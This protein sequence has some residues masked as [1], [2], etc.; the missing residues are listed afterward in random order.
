M[1][2]Q[3]PQAQQYMKQVKR[4][5]TCSRKQRHGLIS[6][7]EQMIGMFS[8]DCPDASYEQIRTA[9]GSPTE[10][11]AELLSDIPEQEMTRICRSKKWI[12]IAATAC[13]TAITIGAC[14]A[15]VYFIRHP[16][17]AEIVTV[18]YEENIPE[19]WEYIQKYGL[20]Y[21]LDEDGN[22]VLATDKDGNEIEVDEK[23]IPI[24]ELKYK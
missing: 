19:G 2:R 8:D 24:R 11:A 17:T 12:R 20:S 23:G 9:C 7:L 16:W 1:N 14:S 6:E 21:E 22:I 5:L 4:Q 10:I 15:V 18:I 3:N 13:L